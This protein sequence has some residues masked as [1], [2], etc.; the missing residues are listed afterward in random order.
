MPICVIPNYVRAIKQVIDS[1][2]ES[3]TN[4]LPVLLVIFAML[5]AVV[6]LPSPF[7]RVVR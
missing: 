2:L 6:V 1:K 5:E 4:L 7:L 3:S